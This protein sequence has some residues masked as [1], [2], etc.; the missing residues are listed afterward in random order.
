M[1][2]VLVSALIVALVGFGGCAVG[3]YPAAPSNE[4]AQQPLVAGAPDNGDPWVVALFAHLPGASA[5]TLCTATLISP[6]VLLTAA[7]CVDPA[8]TGNG[9]I[10]DAIFSTSVGDGATTD[11]HQVSETRF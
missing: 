6:R 1:K 5:G 4:D 3:V 8:E 11:I 9:V 10:F 2:K 7:H